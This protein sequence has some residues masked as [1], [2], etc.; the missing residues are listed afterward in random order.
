MNTLSQTLTRWRNAVNYCLESWPSKLQNIWIVVA[1]A[2]NLEHSNFFGSMSNKHEALSVYTLWIEDSKRKL[3]ALQTNQKKAPAQTST[4]PKEETNRDILY[5]YS[6]I[7]QQLTYL[8]N[9]MRA[10]VRK[11]TVLFHDLMKPASLV[12]SLTSRRLAGFVTNV[13]QSW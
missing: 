7:H 10:S 9:L 4:K 8:L 12:S 13:E 1:R 5:V 6:Y 2:V 3:P 11:G